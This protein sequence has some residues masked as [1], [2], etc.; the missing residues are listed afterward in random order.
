MGVLDSVCTH[1]HGISPYVPGK[2]ITE[3]ARELGLPVDRIVK[4]AS[5][6][7]PLGMSPLAREAAVAVVA[8]GTERYPDQFELTAKLAA[9]L[10]VDAE[11]IVL[12]NGSNDV[13]DL[14]ARVFLAPGRAAVYSQYAFAVYPI[15]TRSAGADGVVVAA[16]D[17]G[18]DLEAMHAAIDARTHLV[19]IANPNNPTG[20]LLS[21]EALR[22]F[23][24]R[25]PR[26]V[27]VVLDEAYNEY[28]P[29]AALADTLR[30]IDE[31]ENLVITR[32][33]SK[34]YGLAG[35][36]V[37][38]AVAS[39]GV[40]GM[41]NRVRQPFNVSSVAL[42]AAAAALDDG[43]FVARSQALNREGMV[44]ME[45]SFH[46]M[47]LSWIPSAGNFVCLEMPVGVDAMAINAA[48]LRRGV[49]V[50]PVGGY[51][52][53]RHLRVSIGLPAE[54]ARFVDALRVALGR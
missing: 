45:G 20:T 23:I 26:H 30:W 15:A 48:L 33:F 46:D 19:W 3:V 13:L 34:I 31:F 37:G 35:L 53:P 36:R 52:M 9:R 21:A 39:R 12:G 38:Y 43:E 50:R 5:N 17:Y 16:R 14:A 51:G 54:N 42:A 10:Q 47:G 44:V 7:N 29:P 28:L 40:A 1:V 25:V 2:P 24:A 8:G 49:I 32:T 6:E 27:A 11:Q 41:M 18:H 4:L 22:A